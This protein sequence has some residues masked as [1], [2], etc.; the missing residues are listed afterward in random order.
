MK[1]P[2]VEV[3]TKWEKNNIG[4]LLIAASVPIVSFTLKKFSEKLPT[5][6]S[7]WPVTTSTGKTQIK[8][9]KCVARHKITH[10]GH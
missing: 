8:W 3:T 7:R 10:D 9:N 2:K 6:L 4:L 5:G 1:Y